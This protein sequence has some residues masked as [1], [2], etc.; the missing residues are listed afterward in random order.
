M[1]QQALKRI[2]PLNLKFVQPIPIPGRESFFA[3][4]GFK[5]IPDH[6]VMEL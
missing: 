6:K 1:L 4:L 2:E 3:K 5:V